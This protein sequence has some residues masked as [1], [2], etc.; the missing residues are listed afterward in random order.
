MPPRGISVAHALPDRIRIRIDALR[1]K[2]W[3]G[4]EIERGVGGVRG[5]HGVEASTITGSV[6]VHHDRHLKPED[7][8]TLTRALLQHVPN[9][10]PHDVGTYLAT[11]PRGP[12]S[13]HAFS[14]HRVSRAFQDLNTR[15]AATTGGVELALLVPLVLVALGVRGLLVNQQ[16]VV[17]RWYDF[18]WFGF[19]T[20]MMLNAAGVPAERAA[21]D[22]VS[23]AAKI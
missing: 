21:E 18:L 14:S 10:D 7:W 22:A 20:F 3:L 6:V 23:L 5:V 19:A 8:Q 15:V 9:L 13:D 4:R 2:A 17:P 12:V 11:H 1:G 16:T